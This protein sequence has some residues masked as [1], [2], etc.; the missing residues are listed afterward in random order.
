MA[1]R[2]LGLF[3]MPRKKKAPRP[4]GKRDFTRKEPVL[5]EAM[6]AFA[7]FIIAK[8]LGDSETLND[9]GV[10]SGKTK[11]FCVKF[12]I[13]KNTPA[14][15]LHQGSLFWD[16]FVSKDMEAWKLK[17]PVALARTLVKDPVSFLKITFPGEM[18]K[19]F[20][21][22]VEMAPAA[23]LDPEEMTEAQLNAELARL[24][25]IRDELKG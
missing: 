11:D 24:K 6:K 23:E 7:R 15:W 8:E 18:K 14:N 1:G 4:G 25:K 22:K 16:Y 12:N 21:Q 10:P 3:L 20:S 17:R 2:P 5:T 19:A 9:L 13:S